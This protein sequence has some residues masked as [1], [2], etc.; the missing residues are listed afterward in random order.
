MKRSFP[1]Q[2]LPLLRGTALQRGVIFGTILVGALLAFEAFN[3]STTG[4]A[5]RDVLGDLG[6]AGVRWSTILTLAFCGIDFAGIARLFTP[7]K[8]RDEPAEVWYLFG[9]WLLA[10]VMNAILTWWGVSVAII[11]HT[12]AGGV[13]VGQATLTKTIP[14]FV[15]VMVWL[16]RVLIIGIF[17]IAG[18]NLFSLAESRPRVQQTSRPIAEPTRATNPA[19]VRPAPKPISAISNQRTSRVEP[20][21]HPVGIS[22]QLYDERYADLRQ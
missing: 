11:N 3:Y 19:Y 7:E 21:Y 10:A 20:S 13:L 4:F 6:F 22:A 1:L 12:P 14:V 5:L 16:I 15:A 8:G 9:A 17:S 18:E 2:I